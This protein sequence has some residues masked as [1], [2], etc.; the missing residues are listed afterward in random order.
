MAA[1]NDE[2][3]VDETADLLVPAVSPDDASTAEASS[4]VQQSR[5]GITISPEQ[6]AWNTKVLRLIQSTWVTPPKYRDS[7]LVTTLKL[8][9]SASGAL[10]GTPEV[11]RPSG[12]PF[13]DDNAVRALLKAAPLP[14]VTE[15][16]PRLF[17]F[18]SEAN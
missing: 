18:R 7:G 10:I 1:F 15:P 5:S 14:P 4:P 9:V 13:F 6:A 2:L 3:G 11:T 12:D 16:G 8:R 17:I